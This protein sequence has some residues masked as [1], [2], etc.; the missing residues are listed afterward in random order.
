MPRVNPSLSLAMPDVELFLMQLQPGAPMLRVPLGASADTVVRRAAAAC[1]VE[2][3][4]LALFCRGRRLGGPAPLS[5]SGI[6]SGAA[7]R[8]T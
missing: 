6:R 1:R 7:L 5:R 4:Q 8:M 3:S 2:P